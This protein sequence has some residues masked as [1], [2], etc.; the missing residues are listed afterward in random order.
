MYTLEGWP[1]NTGVHTKYMALF[2]IKDG[3]LIGQGDGSFLNF[4]TIRLI[5]DSYQRSRL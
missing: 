5:L 1:S 4:L 3:N 2:E